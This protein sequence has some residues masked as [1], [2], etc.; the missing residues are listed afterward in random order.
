LDYDG[1]ITPIVDLP[2]KAVL[3]KE[4]RSL[5]LRLKEIIP[6]AIVSGRSLDDIKRR[7]NIEEMIYAGNHGAEI[8]DGSKLVVGQQLSD[9]KEVLEKIIRELK[10]ALS[11]VRGVVVEDKGITASVH[12][13]MVNAN[14][15]SKMF[16]IFWPIADSYKGLFKITSGKKVFEIRP[17]GIW[18]KGDSVKWIWKNFGKKK[19]PLYIGDDK[20]DEDAFK[21][22]KGRGIGVS[23]GRSSEADYYLKTQEEVKKFLRWIGNF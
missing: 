18:N 22:I 23:I 11:S 14:E 1:T 7:V 12:F 4:M 10:E 15:I 5:I 3:S 9:S 17:H 6:I 19:I 16:D 20:T 2:D 21:V 13:R 8:W